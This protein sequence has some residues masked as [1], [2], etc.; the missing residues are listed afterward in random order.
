MKDRGDSTEKLLQA[1]VDLKDSITDAKANLLLSLGG[2]IKVGFNRRQAQKDYYAA[3]AVKQALLIE[4]K[5]LEVAFDRRL[6][7]LKAQGVEFEK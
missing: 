1:A 2:A 5:R 6:A 7:E 3:K 4:A